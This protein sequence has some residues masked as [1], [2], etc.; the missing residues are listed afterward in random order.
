MFLEF[1]HRPVHFP[2]SLACGP[3][4]PVGVDFPAASPSLG[5][6]SALLPGWAC[7]GGLF[8]SGP[9]C[10][11]PLRAWSPFAPPPEF[12]RVSVVGVCLCFGLWCASGVALPLC[13][14][15]RLHVPFVGCFG[16]V[17]WFYFSACLPA[18]SGL[19]AFVFLPVL[20]F[21]AV[22]GCVALVGLVGGACF[23]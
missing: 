18:S 8:R 22:P 13:L 23:I 9:P 1:I 16:R 17:W 6:C 11:V 4:L 19:G 7:F 12:P 5:C 10:P 21:C 15:V 20:F 2:L 14:W 3:S